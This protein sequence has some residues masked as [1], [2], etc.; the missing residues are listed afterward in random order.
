MSEMEPR[1]KAEYELELI[2]CSFSPN[3]EEEWAPIPFPTQSGESTIKENGQYF[4]SSWGRVKRQTARQG[5][6][7]LSPQYTPIGFWVTMR[8]SNNKTFGRRIDRLMSIF[9]S[10]PYENVRKPIHKDG[11]LFNNN[12]KNL[13]FVVWES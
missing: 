6:K 5:C 2:R 10:I 12:F 3:E 8:D 11:N 7:I 13:E 1:E 9:K 4:I